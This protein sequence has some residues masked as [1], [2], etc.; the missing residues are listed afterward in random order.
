LGREKY[1]K[2]KKKTKSREG[3]ERDRMMVET[4]RGVV[5]RSV[6]CIRIYCTLCCDNVLRKRFSLKIHK[7][8]SSTVNQEGE[9]T[10]G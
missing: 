3:G 8:F 5:S 4:R 1:R 10:F 9:L 7:R 6:I 2:E